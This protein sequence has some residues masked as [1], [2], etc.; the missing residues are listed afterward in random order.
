MLTELSSAVRSLVRSPG[1][2]HGEPFQVE[3][4]AAPPLRH[5]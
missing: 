2:G 3:G 4:A 5:E 1:L